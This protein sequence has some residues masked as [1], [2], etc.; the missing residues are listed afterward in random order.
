MHEAREADVAV[1]GAG[2]AGLAAA[3]AVVAAGHSVV[4]CEARDRVGG[5][6]LDHDLGG[7]QV[8]EAGG[9]WIGGGQERIY[10]LAAELGVE[11]FPGRSEGAKVFVF[12]GKRRTY[13]GELPP[14]RRVAA[15][16]VQAMLRLRRL[17]KRVPAEAPWEARDAERLDAQTLGAWVDRTTKTRAGRALLTLF[18]GIQHGADPA[19]VSLL[20]ALSFFSSGGGFARYAEADQHRLVG[21]SQALSRRLAD[22]LGDA[23]VLGSPVRRIDQSGAEVVVESELVTVRA[24][25]AIV[26][27]PPILSGSIEYR[28]ELPSL[29]RQLLRAV[30]YGVV[31]KA[32]AVYDE[33]FWRAEGLSGTALGPGLAAPFAFDNSPPGGSPGVLLTFLHPRRGAALADLRPAERR[34]AVLE[35]FAT[36]VGPKAR[37]PA[38]YLELDWSAERWSA[39][40]VQYLTPGALTRY[41]PA[42]REPCGRVHWGSENGTVWVASM[43]G[44]IRAGERAA[45]EVL[46]ALAG[47]APAKERVTVTTS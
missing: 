46:A 37:Q 18:T 4:V 23:V 26:A 2:L 21:G 17:E 1:V 33:P 10:E 28:P 5:R 6:T 41:G 36:Y 45:G 12:D 7:G 9:Q 13:D 11:T 20:Y 40:C 32:Q 30:G 47:A 24:R 14:S 22:R 42:L 15:D 31:I 25:R 34:E 44:A 16:L 38:G 35:C 29:R 39:G 27:A 8:V 3:R 19:N 43:E